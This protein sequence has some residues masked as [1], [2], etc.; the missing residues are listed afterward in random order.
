M[1]FIKSR[2]KFFLGILLSFLIVFDMVDKNVVFFDIDL[3]KGFV[4]DWCIFECEKV[5]C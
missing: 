5:E 2:C 4:I 3:F 1:K